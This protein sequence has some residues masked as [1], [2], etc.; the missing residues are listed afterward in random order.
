MF[1]YLRRGQDSD[2]G[3]KISRLG[4]DD[5]GEEPRQKG[6]RYR[7]KRSRRGRDDK[8]K[9]PRQKEKGKT[10][11]RDMLKLASRAAATGRL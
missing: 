11:S 1:G 4:R 9:E 2:G 6:F 5:R 8:A 7:R 3:R 10:E